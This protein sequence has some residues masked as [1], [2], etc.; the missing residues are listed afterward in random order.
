MGSSLDEMMTERESA[1]VRALHD[2]ARRFREEMT[3]AL[4]GAEYPYGMEHDVGNLVAEVEIL[5]VR[6]I[7]AIARHEALASVE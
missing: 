6:T 2:M 3:G 4:R 1:T 5:Y 7:N